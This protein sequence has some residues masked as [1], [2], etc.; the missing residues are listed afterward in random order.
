MSLNFREYTSYII[1][2][3]P[4]GGVFELFLKQVEEG[5]DADN[6]EERGQWASLS[7]TRL[8]MYAVKGDSLYV[9]G[10]PI[11]DVESLVTSDDFRWDAYSFEH[12]PHVLVGDGGE[13][14]LKIEED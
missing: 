4:D 6:E 3:G 12:S 1:G 7:D 10:V 11:V 2:K 9:E 8:N 5:F 14:G 13:G